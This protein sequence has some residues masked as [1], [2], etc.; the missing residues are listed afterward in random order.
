[1][2]QQILLFDFGG[3]LDADGDPW[4]VRFHRDYVA[5]GGR[6]PFEEFAPIFK[7]SDRQL[8]AEPA[9][10]TMGFRALIDAQ[11][12][13]LG[14]LLPDGR[15]VDLGRVADAFHADALVTVER[16]R[17]LLARLAHRYRL[18]VVSNFTG[19]LAPCLDELALLDFFAVIVDSAIVGWAKP[20]PRIF[21]S[22]LAALATSPTDAWM[23]GDNPEADIRAAGALGIRTCWL[24][25]P[26][27][28]PPD[29]I[30]PTARIARLTELPAV[31]AT[32]TD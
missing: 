28:E 22:A 6:L 24:A 25:P 29:G 11:A 30:T 5:G 27:R 23:I 26:E 13:L 12:D 14:R 16:N 10:R 21:Q 15:Q 32:C 7:L 2:N 9:V 18:G 17:G 20:D 1:M 31:I 4:A 8:E 3:T 19:N